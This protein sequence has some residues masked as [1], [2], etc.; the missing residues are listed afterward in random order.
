MAL[1]FLAGSAF[2]NVAP[3][4]GSVASG[5]FKM[6]AGNRA[7]QAGAM[8]AQYGRQNFLDKLQADRDANILQLGQAVQ[9]HAMAKNMLKYQQG[10]AFNE[11][12]KAPEFAS[13]LG[14]AGT[15][16]ERRKRNYFFEPDSKRQRL[17][18]IGENNFGTL[19]GGSTADM[20]GTTARQEAKEAMA[21]EYRRA[22]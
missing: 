4:L 3:I 5:F 17:A 10:L 1:G 13:L 21:R 9:G 18:N 16:I 12:Q 14:Q 8:S 7:A 11:M 2:A 20:F 6:R 15:E 19:W 22:A